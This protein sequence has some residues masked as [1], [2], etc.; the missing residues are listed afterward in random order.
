MLV[1]KPSRLIPIRRVARVFGAA[2]LRGNR[3]DVSS[4]LHAATAFLRTIAEVAPL[5][6]AVDGALMGVALFHIRGHWHLGA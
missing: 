1:A 3:D 4:V 6:D 2:K 5:A